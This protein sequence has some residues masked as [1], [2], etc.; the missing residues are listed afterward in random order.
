MQCSPG[1]SEAGGA[2]A[3]SILWLILV[4]CCWGAT[5]PLLKNGSKGKLNPLPL[6]VLLLPAS[7]SVPGGRGL[8]E[9]GL[10]L[11]PRRTAGVESVHAGGPVQQVVCELLYL[12][13]R[14]QFVVPFGV[15][16]AGSALFYLTLADADLSLAVS[17]AASRNPDPA[18]G[19]T[20]P[21]HLIPAYHSSWS[22]W[23]RR[24]QSPTR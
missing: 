11:Q 3:S 21:R 10:T 6:Q 16:Q 17:N 7:V 8:S 12:A 18:W 20:V 4:S 15:N 2:M 5:N 1:Q 9:W 14:W 22:C 24:R 13:T 23:P 19:F